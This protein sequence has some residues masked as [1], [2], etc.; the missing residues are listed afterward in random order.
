MQLITLGT[1]TKESPDTSIPTPLAVFYHCIDS[2][3][4][5]G[6][7]N[8]IPC[9]LQNATMPE[10]ILKKVLQGIYSLSDNRAVSN[11]LRIPAV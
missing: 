6:Q 5:Q 8:S 3:V 2:T 1:P 10:D 11:S 9:L 7:T 4:V